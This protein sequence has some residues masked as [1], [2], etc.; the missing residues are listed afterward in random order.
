MSPPST[1]RVNIA[2]VNDEAVEDGGVL[3]YKLDGVS[4]VAGVSVVPPF[5]AC[6]H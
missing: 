2:A 6:G 5:G 1:P 3:S 4:G